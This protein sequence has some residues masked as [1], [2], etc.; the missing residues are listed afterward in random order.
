MN[1][2]FLLEFDNLNLRPEKIPVQNKKIKLQTFLIWSG[3]SFRFRNK[4]PKFESEF[5]FEILRNRKSPRN[6]INQNDFLIIDIPTSA[7]T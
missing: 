4:F 2:L 1:E 3:E 5:L 6:L 7:P